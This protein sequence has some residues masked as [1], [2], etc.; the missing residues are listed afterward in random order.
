MPCQISFG[1]VPGVRTVRTPC[2]RDDC[3]ARKKAPEIQKCSHRQ[4]T[5]VRALEVFGN[6]NCNFVDSSTPGWLPH[7]RY[8]PV[9]RRRHSPDHAR[10][11]FSAPSRRKRFVPEPICDPTHVPTRPGRPGDAGKCAT[12]CDRHVFGAGPV[13]VRGAFGVRSATV[14]CGSRGAGGAEWSGVRSVGGALGG[15]GP[16]PVRAGGRARSGSPPVTGDGGAGNSEAD[17][18]PGPGHRRTDPGIGA[19]AWRKARS[20]RGDPP[21]DRRRPPPTAAGPRTAAG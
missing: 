21:A 1:A 10:A 20:A 4:S 2:R 18:D 6:H 19:R 12:T 13:C 15:L 14:R 16:G 9:P 7:C 5:P 8:F 17:P 11:R 3:P